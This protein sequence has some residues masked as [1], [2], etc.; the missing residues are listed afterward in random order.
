MICLKPTAMQ[1]D[2]EYHGFSI[3][4]RDKGDL[5]II[6]NELNSKYVESYSS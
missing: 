4:L 6:V 2:N 3:V 1:L 5:R